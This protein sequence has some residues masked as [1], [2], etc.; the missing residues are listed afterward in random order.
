MR[1]IW[2][3]CLLAAIVAAGCGESTEAAGGAGGGGGVEA[4]CSDGLLNGDETNADCGGGC[5]PCGKGKG[6]EIGTDC[7]TGVC[8]EGHCSPAACDDG[9]RNG[10]E[11]DVDCG[12]VC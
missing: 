10:D 1:E 5:E 2:L 7:R 3:G 9:V 6:C 4:S 8:A 11:S 12:G